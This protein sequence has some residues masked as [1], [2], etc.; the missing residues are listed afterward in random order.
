MNIGKLSIDIKYLIT[1]QLMYKYIYLY[2]M[3]ARA[4]KS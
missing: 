4:V 1:P 3:I 2:V